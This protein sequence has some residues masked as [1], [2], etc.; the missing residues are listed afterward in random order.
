M[1]AFCVFGM[2]E[3][4]ARK[5]AAKAWEKHLATMTKEVRACLTDKDEADWIAVKTEYLLA[6][7]KPVQVSG[8][9]DAPQFARDYIT[10]SQRMHR[11]SRLQIMARGEKRDANGAPVI[12]KATKKPMI[13]WVP[14]SI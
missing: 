2:T 5:A 4:I 1:S 14:H 13:G 3:P 8:A 6:K 12:S 7:A 11:T 10:L 9:F